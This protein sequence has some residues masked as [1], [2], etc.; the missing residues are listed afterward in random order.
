MSKKPKP[1]LSRRDAL[2]VGGLIAGAALAEP[3]IRLATPEYSPAIDTA[4]QIQ[5]QQNSPTDL[6]PLPPLSV[7]ALNRL[8]YGAR[9]GDID[10][11]NA[12]PGASPAIQLQAYVDQQLNPTAIDDSVFDAR[13]TAANLTPLTKTLSQLWSDYYVNITVNGIANYDLRLPPVTAVRTATILRAVFSKKQLF[14]VLTNFWH[15]HFTVFGWDY[16]YASA[17]FAHYDRDVIRANVLG[18]FRQMLEAVGAS[19]AML[20]YLNNYTNKATGPNENYARELLE[21]H[22]LGAENYLGT[23]PASSVPLDA[24]GRPIG[25]VDED[26]FAVA[27][28]FTGWR[29]NDSSTQSGVVND[30]TFLY[31]PAWHDATAKTVLGHPIPASQPALKDGRDVYDLIAAHPG[32][33]RFIARKLCRRL[34]SDNP[35]QSIVD[36]A[37]AVFTAQKD[38]P[39]QLKQVVRAIILSNE[40]MTTW[41]Q[42][43]KTPIEVSM[44]ILRATGVDFTTISDAFFW[45]FDRMGQPFF[46]CRTPNGYPDVKEAW[47]G[48]MSILN[49][50][51][52]CN[53]LLGGRVSANGVTWSVDT[54]SQMPTVVQTPAVIADFWIQRILGRPMYPASSR[55]TIVDFISQG[56]NSS[57]KMTTAETTD[58]VPRMVELIM[59][60]P[61][62]QWR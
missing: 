28:C 50:W 17:T 48:T 42:K 54:V 32:T 7:I 43:V 62:F 21:L 36:A 2:L 41:A 35:P 4:P 33:G 56:R 55:D 47:S 60:C 39:D 11:F 1:D 26:V 20:F 19:P 22:S 52:L 9:P 3:L 44:G 29:V 53:T 8:A 38:A 24:T 10:A 13:L 59:M 18:N 5:T 40:F 6:P 23:V 61:D 31:Y 37:A 57:F 34:I 46:G 58:L 27:K 25:Y 14:E 16:D 12:L 49:R 15:N 30:G 45:T 51:G